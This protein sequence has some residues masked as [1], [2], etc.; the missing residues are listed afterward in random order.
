MAATDVAHFS[1]TGIVRTTAESDTEFLPGDRS[2]GRVGP[3]H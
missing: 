3:A 1:F 2:R